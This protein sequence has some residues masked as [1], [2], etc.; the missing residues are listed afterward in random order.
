MIRRI[1]VSVEIIPLPKHP[2]KHPRLSIM[3]RQIRNEIP[4]HHQTLV[5]AISHRNPSSLR[6]QLTQRSIL[7]LQKS[8]RPLI[9]HL[10]SLVLRVPHLLRQNRLLNNTLHSLYLIKLRER[11]TVKPIPRIHPIHRQK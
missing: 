9:I 7:S 10:L 3:N 1:S 11:L 6:L 2:V 5:R 4:P 8:R